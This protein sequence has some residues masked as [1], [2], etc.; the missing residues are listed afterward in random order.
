MCW[1][2]GAKRRLFITLSRCRRIITG[3]LVNLA[4]LCHVPKDPERSANMDK[5]AISAPAVCRK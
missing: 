4:L 1:Q 5:L 2:A 3:R